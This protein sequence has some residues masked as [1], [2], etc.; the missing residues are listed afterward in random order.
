[1]SAWCA[2]IPGIVFLIL[3]FRILAMDNTEEFNLFNSNKALKILKLFMIIGQVELLV[4]VIFITVKF[5]KE[6]RG[7]RDVT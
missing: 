5:V 7:G 2:F 3:N 1:M 6:F 4:Y